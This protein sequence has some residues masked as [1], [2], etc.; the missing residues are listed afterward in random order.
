MKC[1]NARLARRPLKTGLIY[2]RY[3]GLRWRG[4]LTAILGMKICLMKVARLGQVPVSER[5]L[6]PR[7]PAYN[8]SLRMNYEFRVLTE[9]QSPGFGSS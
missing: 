8:F 2:H 1:A 7:P 6:S 5:L 9:D 3:G 4:G